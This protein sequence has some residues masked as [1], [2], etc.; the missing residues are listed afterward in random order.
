VSDSRLDDLYRALRRAHLRFAG[1]PRRLVVLGCVALA[2][3]CGLSGLRREGADVLVAVRAVPAGQAL[4]AADLAV[5][6]WPRSV[7]PARAL[8]HLA[9]A[10]GRVLAL[11]ITAGEPLTSARLLGPGLAAGRPPGTVV[12]AISVSATSAHAVV[13]PGERVDVLRGIPVQDC[14]AAAADAVVLARAVLVLAILDPGAGTIGGNTGTPDTVADPAGVTVLTI[15]TDAAT[16][17]RLAIQC[18]G[19][20]LVRLRAP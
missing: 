10:R 16:S 7:V 4:T 1:W 17:E 6:H 9:E 13:Q 18:G 2:V 19:P 5:R 11:A 3:G 12:F 8:H 14:P 15:A 20:F